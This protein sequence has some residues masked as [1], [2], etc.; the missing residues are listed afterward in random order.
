MPS[1]IA[2]L[3]CRLAEDA[4]AV[5]RHYLS[6][7][8]RVGNYWLVGDA[9]N[10]PGRSRYVR[11]GGAAVSRGRAGKWVDAATGEFG[12]LF[13]II[14]E[15]C[16]LNATADVA[17]EARC[18]L[19]LT[20]PASLIDRDQAPHIHRA[21]SLQS[22]RRLF[23]MSQ[24][25]DGTLAQTYLR[26]RG[27]TQTSSLSALRYHPRCYFRSEPDGVTEARPAMIAAITDL[28]GN[29]T[30]VQRTWLHASGTGKAP[31]PTPRRAMGDLLGH[32][33]RFGTAAEVLGIGEGVE[34]TLSIRRAVPG[35]PLAAALSAIHLAA[36]HFPTALRRLYILRDN[37]PAGSRAA[38]S[39][40]DRAHRAGIEAIVLVPKLGDFN[41]DLRA[42]GSDGLRANL[43]SQI[44]P[45]DVARLIKFGPEHAG[46]E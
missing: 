37:D 32:A 26:S 22:A 10:A 38:Q 41:D 3:A 43:R 24:A 39:L 9:R 40:T 17:D 8:Q 19:N 1:A 28:A 27:I 45:D 5:C 14:R 20:R 33:V 11:L 4:E 34:T 25:I 23:A 44:A 6:N 7:G 16:G 13:D 35:L 29:I 2:Q 31:I 42:M 15:S 30:G 18:F 36:I 46:K 12:D 21:G